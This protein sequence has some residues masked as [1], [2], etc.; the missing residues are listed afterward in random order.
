MLILVTKQHV[1]YCHLNTK[2]SGKSQ[3]KV[4]MNFASSGAPQFCR[5]L[6]FNTKADFMLLKDE[7][8]IF[9]NLKNALGSQKPATI[10]ATFGQVIC[11]V[12]FEKEK[13]G[14]VSLRNVGVCQI[15]QINNDFFEELMPIFQIKISTFIKPLNFYVSRLAQTIRIQGSNSLNEVEE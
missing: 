14:I 1:I 9:L 4:I 12:F 11:L 2:G 15:F 5:A 10:K 8:F 6:F 3:H 13:V 7:K